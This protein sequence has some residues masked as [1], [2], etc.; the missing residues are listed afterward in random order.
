MTPA[1]MVGLAVGDALGMPFEHFSDQIDPRLATWDGNYVAGSWPDRLTHTLDDKVP[2]PSLPAGCWT[3]DTGMAMALAKSLVNCKGYDPADAAIGYLIWAQGEPCG[4]GG[5]T[6]DALRAIRDGD[7]W[8]LSGKTFDSPEAVGNGTAMRVAPLGAFHHRQNPWVLQHVASLDATVTHA[9]E[10]AMTAST[11]I[12]MIVAKLHTPTKTVAEVV[13]EVLATLDS[14]S[15][16]GPNTTRVTERLRIALD[17][18]DRNTPT[19]EAI[20]RL[21]RRGNAAQTVASAVYCALNHPDDFA[22]GVRMAVRGGGD[23]D[24]RAAITGALL[25]TRLGLEAIPA[26][27]VSGLKDSQ[28]LIKLDT[29]LQQ[30]PKP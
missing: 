13:V 23:T 17:L 18:H 1:T 8:N 14:R 15:F 27:W 30:G 29:L 11:V 21:G 16:G 9:H 22:T 5:S 28:H 19:Q 12:A 7:P 4:M 24:T 3:D 2:M 6:R 25:G 26:P 10:E 20:D